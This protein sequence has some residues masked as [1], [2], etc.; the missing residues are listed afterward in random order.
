MLLYENI[1]C[2]Y[3]KLT[4]HKCIEYMFFPNNTSYFC[5]N[6]NRVRQKTKFISYEIQAITPNYLY[7]LS[8]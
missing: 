7:Q 8:N 3:C 2:F 5:S 6:T 1:V 4:H